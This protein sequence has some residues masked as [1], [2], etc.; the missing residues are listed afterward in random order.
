MEERVNERA[1]HERK[2]VCERVSEFL[3]ACARTRM[4]LFLHCAY[5]VCAI[6]CVRLC[7]C[8]VAGWDLWHAYARWWN[9]Q[10]DVSSDHEPL[11]DEQVNAHTSAHKCLCA[12]TCMHTYTCMHTHKHA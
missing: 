7:V 11:R 4:R 6:V 8:T 12:H 3:C 9:E 10:D 1:A 2:S 5:C